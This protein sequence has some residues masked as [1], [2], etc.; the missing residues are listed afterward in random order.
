MLRKN[1]KG[2]KGEGRKIV[3]REKPVR[4]I[5]VQE[6]RQNYLN[7]EYELRLYGFDTTKSGFS[8]IG[9]LVPKSGSAKGIPRFVLRLDGERNLDVDIRNVSKPV[10]RDFKAGRNGY[11]GH[12]TK[13]L[14]RSNEREVYLKTP[15]GLIYHGE[16][17]FGTTEIKTLTFDAILTK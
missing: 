5:K 7:P 6:I 1:P 12:R 10:E 15:S 2:N 17:F 16:L 11:S 4:T 14:S 3:K 13:E 9:E 8:S